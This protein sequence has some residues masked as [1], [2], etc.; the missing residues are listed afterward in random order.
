MKQT[1]VC[2]LI[3]FTY[4]Q[5][6]AVIPDNILLPFVRIILLNGEFGN[7]FVKSVIHERAVL[8]LAFNISVNIFYQKIFIQ[9]LP[10][11]EQF[12]EQ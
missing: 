11:P 7:G 9:I 5:H 6:I 1:C 2:Y 3:L 10:F 12:Q 8:I 4:A